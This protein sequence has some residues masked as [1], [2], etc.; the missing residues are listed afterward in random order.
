MHILGSDENGML[1]GLWVGA[2]TGNGI[3]DNFD[4]AD[5]KK[6]KID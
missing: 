6:K 2:N 5:I 3:T 1:K 4:V